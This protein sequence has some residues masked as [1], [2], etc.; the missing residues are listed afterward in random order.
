VEAV[1]VE[2]TQGPPTARVMAD[3]GLLAMVS[4]YGATV[5]PELVLDRASLLLR[6]STQ[7]A[8]G[9][10]Q[11]RFVQY[12]LWIGVLPDNANPR[13]PLTA[14]FGGLDLFWPNHIELTPQEGVTAEGLF[15]STAEAWLETRDFQINPEGPSYFLQAETATTTGQKLFAAALSGVF[16]S[17]F[18]DVPK[19]VR[20]G[21]DET[22]PDLPTP[23]ESRVIVIADSDIASAFVQRRQNLDFLVQ[24]ALWLCTD[25][26]IIAIRSRNTGARL[27]KITNPQHRAST[28]LWART[29]NVVLIPLAVIIAGVAL[30]WRRQRRAHTGIPRTEY[31][32]IEQ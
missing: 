14:R 17:F 22:L 21:A 30:A 24:A 5:K 31:R 11:A 15:S 12:P 4:F 3:R 2:T 6:Y 1:A 27:D 28:M 9:A 18:A 19:P 29:L 13:H 23:Q 26:D 10:V 8:S 25:D 32:E 16:P 20:E 7:T